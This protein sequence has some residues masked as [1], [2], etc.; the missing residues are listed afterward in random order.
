MA[1]NDHQKLDETGQVILELIRESENTKTVRQN[2]TCGSIS[3]LK[4]RRW[5]GIC[6][7]SWCYKGSWEPQ[8][9]DAMK[10]G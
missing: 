7:I 2:G 1:M 3:D 9:I 6:R 8:H 5:Y 4:G 10:H